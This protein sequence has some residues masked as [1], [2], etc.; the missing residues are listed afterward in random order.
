LILCFNLIN[1]QK[2]FKIS[3]SNAYGLKFQISV[4]K[5]KKNLELEIFEDL[6]EADRYNYGFY[7][8]E[9][10]S[11]NKT[12]TI[13][14][15]TLK[16]L[17]EV[18]KF[19][20]KKK[21]SIDKYPKIFNQ[22]ENL[23]SKARC[24][25]CKEFSEAPGMTYCGTDI[26]VKINDK[27]DLYSEHENEVKSS[28]RYLFFMIKREFKDYIIEEK[29]NTFLEYFD[30]NYFILNKNPLI[31]EI[32]N[33]YYGY[34]DDKLPKYELPKADEI[35][36]VLKGRF[37]LSTDNITYL[38]NNYEN[39]HFLVNN[40]FFALNDDIGLEERYELDFKAHL[41]ELDNNFSN[42]LTGIKYTF[43][44]KKTSFN[45]YLS[46][47]HEGLYQSSDTIINNKDDG[48]KL[49]IFKN[50]IVGFKT[51]LLFSSDNKKVQ[52]EIWD[53]FNFDETI[54]SYNRNEYPNF[55]SSNGV[56]RRNPN[57]DNF[58]IDIEEK[59]SKI[60]GSFS[61]VLYNVKTKDSIQIEQGLFLI[62]SKN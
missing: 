50:H 36:L 21:V 35:Y 28:Y 62:D 48:T 19:S 27:T 61:G 6:I 7:S 24:N 17:N 46:Y 59:D 31:V 18:L 20:N 4:K 5:E 42:R 29:L 14:K 52:F 44:N 33:K 40:D 2:E 37:S 10:K 11:Y 22:L 23:Y 41:Q 47:P 16:K 26:F 30:I 1:A 51:G 60:T 8:T 3:F 9:I 54:H 13:S 25:L 34:N 57:K 43:Q 12:D 32:Y 45:D 53:N 58:K 56:Y 55:E 49:Y 39:V 15:S 38:K